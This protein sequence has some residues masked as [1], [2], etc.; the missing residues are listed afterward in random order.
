[1][2]PWML[3]LLV[4]SLL[5]SL[6]GAVFFRKVFFRQHP[7]WP[8]MAQRLLLTF[9]HLTLL[10]ELLYQRFPD[11]SFGSNYREILPWCSS[12]A[13]VFLLILTLYYA[14]W[15]KHDPKATTSRYVSTLRWGKLLL[16]PCLAAVILIWMRH[17]LVQRVH[18]IPLDLLNLFGAGALLLESSLFLV[19]LVPYLRNHFTRLALRELVEQLPQ[20]V[21]VTNTRGEILLANPSFHHL[22]SDLAVPFSIHCWNLFLEQSGS[23]VPATNDAGKSFLIQTKPLRMYLKTLQLHLIQDLR[24]YSHETR[25]YLRMKQFFE[26][27]YE[28]LQA[29]LSLQFDHGRLREQERLEKHIQSSLGSAIDHVVAV[30]EFLSTET[31]L[32]THQKQQ[33]LGESYRIL[34]AACQEWSWDVAKKQLP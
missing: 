13:A 7:F 1:M 9:I 32:S 30:T 4:L 8:G 21:V 6:V 27:R 26:D 17:P 34:T 12:L 5:L 11:L 18:G 10:L 3:V 24:S 15:M 14:Y 29:S 33:H 16:F 31:E 25:N 20:A 23:T 28:T 2:N 22:C 19:S